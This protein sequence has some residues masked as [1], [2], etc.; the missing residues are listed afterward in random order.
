MNTLRKLKT[1]YS[2][3]K[4]LSIFTGIA[5]VLW[6]LTGLAIT[7][8]GSFFVP[9]PESQY[10]PNTPDLRQVT[11]SPREAVA[12]LGATLG[13]TP[14]IRSV[15]LATIDDVLVYRIVFVDDSSHMID[16]ATGENF[17]LTEELGQ[18]IAFA[19]FPSG[20]SVYSV[21]YI[22]KNDMAYL[23]ET[24]P[25]YRYQFDDENETYVHVAVATGE[26]SI[27][28]RSSRLISFFTALHSFQVL[29]PLFADSY[30]TSTIL[31]WISNILTVLAALS[32]YYLALPPR[33]QFRRRR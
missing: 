20:G 9:W 14:A 17:L 24:V 11:M 12:H 4:W 6:L 19:A 22:E 1:W 27:S 31:L 18:K 10:V 15:E 13:G 29:N 30:R 32:G 21:H 2:A 25:A 7:L 23:Y 26:V 16:T 5:L 33:W 3:H 8:P 28:H